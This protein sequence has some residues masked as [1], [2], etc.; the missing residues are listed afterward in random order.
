MSTLRE[1]GCF[2]DPWS[3]R[4]SFH[5]A[6]QL[7]GAGCEHHAMI[8]YQYKE[9]GNV[10]G[11]FFARAGDPRPRGPYLSAILSCVCVSKSDA[12]WRSCSWVSGAPKARLT[13]L[14][15]FTAGRS[16]IIFAQRFTWV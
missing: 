3:V 8:Q 6:K 9:W 12:A 1:E 2:S 11:R 5:L 14:P 4:I 7:K 13:I 15:R 16:A 10:G